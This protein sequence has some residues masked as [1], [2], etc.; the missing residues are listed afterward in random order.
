[1]AVGGPVLRGDVDLDVG[2]DAVVLYAPAGAL[3]P[4]RVP[5]LGHGR[6]VDQ[7]V[8]PVDADHATPGASADDRADAVEREAGGDDVAVGAGVLV[9]HRDD[10]AAR[11]VR[12]IGHRRVAPRVV[13]A[14]DR[15]GE[16]LQHQL[17]GVA[18]VVVPDVDDQ[19]LPGDLEDEVAV[20]LRPAV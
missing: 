16:L 8:A 20:Q 10:R 3:E 12:G 19:A 15:T 18:A 5:R 7:R 4:Q 2:I 17:G 14:L 11:R 6:A 1:V 9:G 13:P